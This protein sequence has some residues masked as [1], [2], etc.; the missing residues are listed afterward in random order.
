M[1]PSRHDCPF[2]D[3]GPFGKTGA[4]G[5]LGREPGGHKPC[6]MGGGPRLGGLPEGCMSSC[7]LT[8][9]TQ[10]ASPSPH[11]CS[12]RTQYHRRGAHRLAILSLSHGRDNA[13]LSP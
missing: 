4:S 5:T 2:M 3:F 11:P 6:L 9:C 7:P 8:P 10:R 13:S 12:H 1:G